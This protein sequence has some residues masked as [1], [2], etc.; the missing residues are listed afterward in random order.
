AQIAGQEQVTR[1]SRKSFGV[2]NWFETAIDYSPNNG[3]QARTA[4][5]LLHC[6]AQ[7]DG[8]GRSRVLLHGYSVLFE[9]VLALHDV[10]L[11]EKI[12]SWEVLRGAF[13]VADEASGSK[14]DYSGLP[15]AQCALCFRSLHVTSEFRLV[16]SHP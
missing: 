12:T 15:Q 2:P 9:C 4:Q 6:M 3:H 8:L 5:I 13:N 10:F 1:D 11:Q 16:S 7:R 14:I